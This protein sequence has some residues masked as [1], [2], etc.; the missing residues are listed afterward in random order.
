MRKLRIILPICAGVIAIAL[1]G[2]SAMGIF[3]KRL[4]TEWKGGPGYGER[5]ETAGALPGD[6]SGGADISLLPGMP[7]DYVLTK[8][9]IEQKEAIGREMLPVFPAMQPGI[10]YVEG[11]FLF[12]AKDQAEAEQIAGAYD[13]EFVSFGHGVG[14]ARIRGGSPYTLGDLLAASADTGNN[15]PP[16]ELNM[17]F[18]AF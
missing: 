1:I 5:P 9:Q 8:K 6:G 15:L 3:A 16:I 11:E 2:G 13:G 4:D 10:A 17:V 12:Q 18:S 14:V 7:E